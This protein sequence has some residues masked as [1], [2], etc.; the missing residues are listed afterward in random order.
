MSQEIES[1][2]SF[3]DEEFPSSLQALLPEALK[4][5]YMQADQLMVDTS[6]LSN[7]GGKNCKGHLIQCS[8]DF[9]LIRLIE[10][11]KLPFDYKWDF[12]AKPTGKHLKILPK[13]TVITVSQLQQVSQFPR[14]ASFRNNQRLNN[15]S[16]QMP[17]FANEIE[18]DLSSVRGRPHLILG[19]GY[20]NLNFA[21]IYVPHS[22]KKH[23]NWRTANLL[24]LPH[25]VS[26]DLPP[27]EGIKDVVEP[28]IKEEFIEWLKKTHGNN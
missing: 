12:H 21:C 14:H 9:Q 13:N 8:V 25:A 4:R 5:A 27:I 20:Q 18:D 2:Q 19:H 7:E 11:G 23:W 16:L 1:Y 24:N 26:S 17:L 15:I 6:F 3:V 10:S 22:H 28:T